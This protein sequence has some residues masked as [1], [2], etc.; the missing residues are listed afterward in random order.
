[1]ALANHLPQQD[2]PWWRILFHSYMPQFHCA[3]VQQQPALTPP[4]FLWVMN[5]AIWLP[6][7]YSTQYI[8]VFLSLHCCPA[9]SF[10]L[11]RD[12]SLCCQKLA[13]LLNL[14]NS[15]LMCRSKKNLRPLRCLSL[16][17]DKLHPQENVCG[18]THFQ[19]TA[20]VNCLWKDR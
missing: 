4:V 2:A 10:R 15:F 1:M 8:V 14:L 3:V 16:A 18:C 12:Y 13:M 5:A 7:T 6:D 11:F 20:M 19:H 17:L 9:F